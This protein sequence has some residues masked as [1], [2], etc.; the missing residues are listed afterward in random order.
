MSSVFF[1]AGWTPEV[2]TMDTFVDSSWYFLRYGDNRNNTEL[3]SLTSQEEWMPIDI[4]FGGA[5][6][7]TMHLLYSRFWQKALFDLG[8]VTTSEPYKHRI[9]RGLVLGPMVTKCRNQKGML[10][11]PMSG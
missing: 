8:L 4:Y 10:S 3:A 5:E 9:N 6:H 11:T 7:T 1:G 2:E